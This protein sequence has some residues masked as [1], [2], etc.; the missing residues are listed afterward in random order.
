MN[1]TARPIKEPT[2]YQRGDSSGGCI[3][4]FHKYCYWRA[5]IRTS[6]AGVIRS[7][8]CGGKSFPSSFHPR[9][10]VLRRRR[11]PPCTRHQ[12]RSFLTLHAARPTSFSLSLPPFRPP[13][14]SGAFSLSAPGASYGPTLLSR[15]ALFR[16]VEI[17]CRCTA[18][19]Q[20]FVGHGSN[21][22]GGVNGISRGR[23][24]HRCQR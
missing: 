1:R 9:S 17:V 10:P 24:G 22:K 2:L 18:D 12:P 21:E 15:S 6:H 20:P 3:G 13:R 8:L 5:E 4:A 7:P 11:A 14:S 16:A 23:H 19:V